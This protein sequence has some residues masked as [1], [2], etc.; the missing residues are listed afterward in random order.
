MAHRQHPQGSVH[1]TAG[2]S[3]PAVTQQQIERLTT[4]AAYKGLYQPPQPSGPY[5]SPPSSG[6]PLAAS[7]GHASA[8]NQP[9]DVR[10]APLQTP[11]SPP[12]SFPDQSV[13]SEIHTV[14]SSDGVRY[15]YIGPRIRGRGRNVLQRIEDMSA[16]PDIKSFGPYDIVCAGC[17][18]VCLTQEGSGIYLDYQSSWGHHR[19]ST[20]REWKSPTSAHKFTAAMRAEHER[21]RG[22][23]R[24]LA[25]A[26]LQSKGYLERVY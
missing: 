5:L 16:D 24:D 3:Q 11:L 25:L 20:L 4:A 14:F 17:S 19:C 2:R 13:R 6:P 7:S 18:R 22:A 1:P 12:R 21:S 10:W 23:S 8:S 26:H 15:K 9:L